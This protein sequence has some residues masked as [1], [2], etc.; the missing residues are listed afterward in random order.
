MA[1]WPNAGEWHEEAKQLLEDGAS[2]REV[3]RTVNID[4]RRVQRVFPGYG[5]THREGGQF[6][7]MVSVHGETLGS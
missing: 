7:K 6:R 5:W 3:A 2:Y 1:R 4:R